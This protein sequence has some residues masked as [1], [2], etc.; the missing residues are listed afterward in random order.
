MNCP[1][2]YECFGCIDKSTG[3]CPLEDTEDDEICIHCGNRVDE[4]E[5]ENIALD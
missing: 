3:F 2:D 1:W 4:C 5:C